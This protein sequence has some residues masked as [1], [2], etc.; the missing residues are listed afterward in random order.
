VV[1]AEQSRDRSK[2]IKRRTPV[3]GIFPNEATADQPLGGGL[4]EQNDE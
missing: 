3:V 2:K 1:S 4:L